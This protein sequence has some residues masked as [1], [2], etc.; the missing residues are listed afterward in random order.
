MVIG[1]QPCKKMKFKTLT[2]VMILV[3]LG[4]EPAIAQSSEAFKNLQAKPKTTIS[5]TELLNNQDPLARIDFG[6]KD[7]PYNSD[8]FMTA[9]KQGA[10]DFARARIQTYPL[11]FGAMSFG[12]HGDSFYGN[13]KPRF[14]YGPAIRFSGNPFPRSFGK[15][16]FRYQLGSKT[17]DTNAMLDTSK[18]YVDLLANY[19]TTTER[20]MIRPGI[21]YK[22]NDNNRI[23]IEGKWMGRINNMMLQYAGIRYTVKF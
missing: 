11:D 1:C 10:R 2:K 15:I 16:D 23:G 4:S 12:L 20:S 22:L 9:E 21:D 17:F 14:E 18:L 5:L 8:F 19:N 13:T 7:I 6:I 3:A